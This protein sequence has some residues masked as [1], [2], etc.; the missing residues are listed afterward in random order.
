MYSNLDKKDQVMI[1]S[2][3]AAAWLFISIGGA[4]TLFGQPSIIRIELGVVMDG[5][6]WAIIIFGAAAA[7]GVA[8]GKYWWEWISSWLA[9]GGVFVYFS[10]AWYLMFHGLPTILPHACYLTSLLLFMVYRGIM[11]A[12]HARK[13]RQILTSAERMVR[14]SG[15][16][17]DKQY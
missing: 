7:I 14:G 3:L 8:I 1:R 10:G 9:A 15:H 4:A 6:A 13:L 11:N 5:A 17:D 2:I 16:D 12:A